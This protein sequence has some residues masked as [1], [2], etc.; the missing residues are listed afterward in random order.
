MITGYKGTAKIRLAM[1]A[2]EVDGACWIWDSMRSTARAMLDAKGD[3]QL[4]PFIINERKDDPELKNVALFDEV[5]KGQDREAFEV[6][7]GPGQMARPFSLP[8]GTPKERVSILRAAFKATLED[9]AFLADV[10]KAKLTVK[11]IPGE[12]AEEIVKR[13]YSMPP[14][15]KENLKFLMPKRKKKS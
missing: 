13:I 8:P 5:F 3:D 9:P 11:H 15:V 12:K 6:W 14:E 7:N 4:I 1:K 10:K 2:K